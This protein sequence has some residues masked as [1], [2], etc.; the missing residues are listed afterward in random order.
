MSLTYV[1]ENLF[2][3]S[4]HV[5]PIVLLLIGGVSAFMLIASAVRGIELQNPLDAVLIC[6]FCLCVAPSWLVLVY[7]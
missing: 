7:V 3:L 6:M 2:V 5:I 4:I 1:L